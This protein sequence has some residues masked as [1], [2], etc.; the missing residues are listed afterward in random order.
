MHVLHA[1]ADGE[2][3][4]SPGTRGVARPAALWAAAPAVV[5]AGR[6]PRCARRRRHAPGAARARSRGLCAQ[7]HDGGAARLAVELRAACAA[8]PDSGQRG[9]GAA[10]R[11]VVPHRTAV[12]G[13]WRRPA[14]PV[15]AVPARSWAE[16][17]GGGGEE[18]TNGRIQRDADAGG[19]RLCAALRAGGAKRK[20]QQRGRLRGRRREIGRENGARAGAGGEKEG[21]AETTKGRRQC[22][23]DALAARSL[24][25]PYALAG[26]A[27]GV[28]RL[29]G[30]CGGA[31]LKV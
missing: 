8:A 22:D 16:G 18:A 28:V 9:G 10:A 23:A 4:A 12:V 13:V 2:H 15:G 6:R 30:R 3:P 14:Q 25:Q 17:A 21:R 27:E 1:C 31:R 20:V 19:T 29:G 24:L 26:Q 5:A 7:P 11:V